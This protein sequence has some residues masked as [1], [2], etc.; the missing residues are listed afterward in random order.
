MRSQAVTSPSSMP[1]GGRNA[2]RIL[3]VADRFAA[4]LALKGVLERSGYL[5]DSAASSAE[6]MNKIEASQFDL[7]LCD[8][9]GDAT[10]GE[11][12]RT[13]ARS[14]PYRPATAHLRISGDEAGGADEISVE[15]VNVPELL[16]EIT[17]LLAL[18]ASDR[19]MRLARVAS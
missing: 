6:A 7:V 14:Q 10:A 18:R 15:P 9:H 11:R 1:I 8:I 4:R 2:V 3:L 16:T 5:V 17:E 13:L 12:L 19:A